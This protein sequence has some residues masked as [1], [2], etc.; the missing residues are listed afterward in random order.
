MESRQRK[1]AIA[2]LAGAVLIGAGRAP[3]AEDGSAAGKLT[4]GSDTGAL[5]FAYA[6]AE[7]GFF[8]KTAEDVRVLLSDVP[9]SRRARENVFELTRLAREDAARVV[10]VL[11]VRRHVMT[12]GAAHR[13]HRSGTR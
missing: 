1:L 6:S 5:R 10:E 9:L 2:G 13:G 12:R 3:A 7:P 11:P 8:D 4:L